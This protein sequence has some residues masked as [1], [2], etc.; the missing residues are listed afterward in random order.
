MPAVASERVLKTPT[1]MGGK[2]CIGGTRIAV[3]TLVEWKKLGVSDDGLLRDYP[4]LTAD[5]LH[6]AWDYYGEHPREIDADILE[7]NRA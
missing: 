6:A 7:N 2:A 5:D 1:V 3:W 4:D